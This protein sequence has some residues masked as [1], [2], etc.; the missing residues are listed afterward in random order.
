M[1]KMKK[2]SEEKIIGILGG[3]GPEATVELF[4]EI[5]NVTPVKRDQDHLRVIIDCNPKIPDRPAAILRG[6]KTP[7]PELVATARNL[8]KAGAT[9][10]AMPC[11]TAHYFADKIRAAVSI[12]FVDILEPIRPFLERKYPKARMVGVLATTATVQ[13]RLFE[14]Y[15]GKKY[16]ILYPYVDPQTRVMDT[17]YEIKKANKGTDQLDLLKKA[18]RNLIR[19]GAQVLIAGCTELPIL[20]RQEH[21]KAP[22]INPLQL[23]AKTLVRKAKINQ[24]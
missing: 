16:E 6:G 21:F 12:E 3:M 11:F 9:I 23:L 17:I 18:G 13:C 10:L 20:L 24:S 2:R 22:L 19:Q 7:V 8:E 4:R 5:V 1:R 15:L 14:R